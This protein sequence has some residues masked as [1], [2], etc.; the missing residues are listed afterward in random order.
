MNDQ[1]VRN[2]RQKIKNTVLE[3]M[4]YVDD[5]SLPV[6]IKRIVKSIK[7]CKLVPYS[8]HMKKYHMSYK[9][10]IEFTE[11]LDACTDYNATTDRYIIYY[12]DIEKNIVNSN[13]YRWNIAHELGH[14]MLN[15]HK[16]NYK[17]R[18]FRSSLSDYEYNSLEIEANYFA[19]YLLVPYSVLY[20]KKIDD[21]WGMQQLCRISGKASI[22]RFEEYCKWKRNS[23]FKDDYDKKVAKL[24]IKEHKCSLCETVLIGKYTKYC[25]I[26]GNN[27]FYFG[28]EYGNMIYPGLE[29][30]NGKVKECPVCKNEQ[31][32]LGEY[33]PVCGTHIVNTCTNEFCGAVQ[34]GYARYCVHCGATTSFFEDNLLKSWQDVQENLI[35]DNNPLDKLIK[36]FGTIIEDDSDEFFDL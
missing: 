30:E 13:R 35:N 7:N 29:T 2:T 26:C 17:T 31:L 25:P 9:E 23:C 32:H 36:D 14:I 8:R 24:F 12:N 10:M 21:V 27:K 16:E 33:C 28:G 34:E 1:D 5:I 3:A 15:H 11:S 18:I 19:A 6:P 20:I 22:F 4:Q